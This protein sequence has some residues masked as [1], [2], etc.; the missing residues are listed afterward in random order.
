MSEET[1]APVPEARVLEKRRLSVVW[2]IPLVAALIG[3]WLTWKSVSEKGPAFSITFPT[4]DGIEAGKT[5]I[6]Y[7]ELEVGVVESL[8]LSDDLTHVVA[9]ARLSPGLDRYLTEKT[10]FWVVRARVSAGQ[11]SGLGTLLSGAYIGIDPVPEGAGRRAF[12]G[13]QD[14]PLVTSQQAGTRFS[15]R[16]PSMGSLDVGVPVHYRQV[17]VGEVVRTHLEDDGS[18]VT[19]DVFVHAPHDQ[20]IRTTTRWWNASGFDATVNQD[21]L[22]IETQSFLS[23]LIGGIAFDTPADEPG[24]AVTPETEFQLA[25]TR[26]AAEHRQYSITRRYLVRFDGSVKGLSR[27]SP[28]EFLGT[29]IGS[30]VEAK[31]QYDAATQTFETPVVIELEPERIQVVGGSPEAVLDRLEALVDEGLR[32]RLETGNLLTGGILV[33]L[34]LDK[35]AKKAGIIRTGT[36]PELP[37]LPK[38]L[39]ELAANVRKLVEKIEDIPLA[40]IGREFE[41]ALTALRGTLEES[42]GAAR[43]ANADLLPALG[44]TMEEARV[45]LT[46]VQKTLESTEKTIAAAGRVIDVSPSP[47]PHTARICCSN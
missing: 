36:Y 7:R 23:M 6:R 41:R 5:K 37:T 12:E 24:Q 31:L 2:V 22:R 43:Q 19:I 18:S 14:P 34:E 30:V 9:Q 13:L 17:Q 3:A 42:R 11:V 26:S 46:G 45:T 15:L 33:N 27:G 16:A 44:R 4:A 40:D 29:R 28:V 10:R 35:N 39:D 20:R 47:R 25:S 21:G 1:P 38:R 8:K 32:V